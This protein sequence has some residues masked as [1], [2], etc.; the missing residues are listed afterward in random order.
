VILFRG[1]F[2]RTELLPFRRLD[3]VTEDFFFAS[4]TAPS[5][6]VKPRRRERICVCSAARQLDANPH[7][8]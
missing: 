8:S 1:R 5:T 3:S 7:G 6:R 4:L 2:R